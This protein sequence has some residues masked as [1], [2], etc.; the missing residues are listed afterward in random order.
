MDDGTEA[1]PHVGTLPLGEVFGRS[2]LDFFA[3]VIAGQAPIPPIADS[4]PMRF[5]AASEGR[6]VVTGRPERRFMNPIGS[7]HGGY[8]AVLLDTVL[9]CAVHTTLGAGEGYTTLEIKCSFHRALQPDTG[10]ITATGTVI[11]RGR[12]AAS[13][14][15]R[16]EDARGRL[17]ASGSSTCL[18]FPLPT[19]AA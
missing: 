3:A 8:A 11:S 14:E 4:V 9:G 6:I 7:I 1:A 15:A 16:I 13:S 18:I 10:E 5:I 19:D 17:L 2:G 12:R